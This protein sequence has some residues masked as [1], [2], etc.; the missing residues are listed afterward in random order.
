MKTL[1]CRNFR[2]ARCSI[3]G[4]AR[5]HVCSR[6]AAARHLPRSSAAAVWVPVRT[7]LCCVR[8]SLISPAWRLY[9]MVWSVS[10]VGV[11]ECNSSARQVT[12][13]LNQCKKPFAAAPTLQSS[14]RPSLPPTRPYPY[15]FI[16]KDA[17]GTRRLHALP[18]C[19]PVICCAGIGLDVT[20][21]L[22][23]ALG[24]GV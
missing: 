21:A 13:S 17:R 9:A 18:L 14:A 20:D 6:N 15:P 7:G 1:T 24:S 16:R 5:F 3:A 22:A 23:P 4:R 2:T 10:L 12:P 8:T 19:K 11:F